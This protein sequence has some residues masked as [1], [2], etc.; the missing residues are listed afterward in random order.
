M[1]SVNKK[2]KAK[3]SFLFGGAEKYQ[4]MKMKRIMYFTK[5]DRQTNKQICKNA[6]GGNL[7]ETDN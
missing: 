4:G 2:K 1:T 3:N 7:N 5:A 6:A